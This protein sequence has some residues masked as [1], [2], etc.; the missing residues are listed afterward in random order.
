MALTRLERFMSKVVVPF[1][2]PD[3]CWWWTANSDARGY[4]FLSTTHGAAPQRAHRAAWELA[5]GPIPDGMD[6]CHHCDNPS[7]V[8]PSHLF[9]GTARDNLRDASAKG[10]IGHNPN[11]RANL[12]PGAPG[13]RGAGPTPIG[14]R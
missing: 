7:C 8:R 5:N 11:S 9:L 14:A 2:D 6:V 10:R 1:G 12:R 4:G 3:G 13:V